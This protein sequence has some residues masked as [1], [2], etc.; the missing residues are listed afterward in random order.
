MHEDRDHILRCRAVSHNVWRHKLLEKLSDTCIVH[1]TYEPLCTLLLDATRK[2]LYSGNDNQPDDIPQCEQYSKELRPLIRAQTQ[3]GWR[4]LFNGR[5]CLQWGE[6]QN[7][8]LYRFRNDLPTKNNLG[9]KWQ[10]TIITLIWEQWYD[11]WKIRNADV[12]GTD[13]A[14]RAIAERRE[15]TQ[16]LASIYSQRNHME[17]SFQALLFPDLQSHL[18]QPTWV[19]QN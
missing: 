14:A 12:H 16:G 17:Q 6:I 3:I 8:H 18:E 15:V 1:H 4:Q 13:D 5:F 11:L 19:I 9:Q 10:V 7:S 2:W